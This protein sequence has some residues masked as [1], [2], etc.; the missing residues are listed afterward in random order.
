MT[1]LFSFSPLVI[2]FIFIRSFTPSRVNV[3]LLIAELLKRE[4]LRLIV[5]INIVVIHH[6]KSCLG[7]LDLAGV[8]LVWELDLKL[9]EKV[10]ELVG[11]P[12]EGKALLEDG[13]DHLG[14]DDITSLVLHADLG[15]VD[16]VDQEV[17]TS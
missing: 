3:G 8:E 11:L 2:V 17:D 9:D 10:S 15:H 5:H 4:D 12:V 13:L 16:V 14:L 1:L 6:V 7:F